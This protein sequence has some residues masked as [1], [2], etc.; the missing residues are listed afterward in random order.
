MARIYLSK[1][2]IPVTSLPN[3]SIQHDC[4]Y[5]AFSRIRIDLMVA[6]AKMAFDA[7]QGAEQVMAGHDSDRSHASAPQGPESHEIY[8]EM[9]PSVEV[10][11]LR[12]ASKHGKLKIV[13]KVD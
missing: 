6:A 11:G 13:G 1:S 2:R 9:D 4:N 10:D 8:P 3:G 12:D 7:R 5:E